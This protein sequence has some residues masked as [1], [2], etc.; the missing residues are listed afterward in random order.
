MIIRR[1]SKKVYLDGAVYRPNET[2][3]VVQIYC[4]DCKYWETHKGRSWC[5]RVVGGCGEMTADDFCSRG[6]KK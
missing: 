5:E 3:E 1:I 4:R 2:S 6:E